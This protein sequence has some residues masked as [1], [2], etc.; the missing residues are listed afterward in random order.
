MRR[1]E[2]PTSTASGSSAAPA[3]AVSPVQ[4]ESDTTARQR[5]FELYK[6]H[7][8]QA[9][10]DKQASADGFDKNLLTFSSGAL[11]V[12]LAFVKDVVPLAHARHMTLLYCS[13]SGL[14][15]CV[16]FTI[17]SFPFSQMAFVL[18]DK[19]LQKY[20]L[21]NDR[22]YLNPPNIWTGCVHACSV[23]GGISFLFGIVTTVLFVYLNLKGI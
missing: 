20:Y 23:A 10:T 17:F 7:A 3:R 13:W 11:G 12:S 2:M 22:K 18:H 4:P 5:A 16:I 15:L 14:V 8:Q 21:D 19:H 1:T 9:W 6:M